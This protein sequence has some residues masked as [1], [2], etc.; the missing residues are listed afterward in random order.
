MKRQKTYRNLLVAAFLINLVGIAF[1]GYKKLDNSIPNDINI[2]VNKS[3]KFDFSLPVEAGIKA[4]DVDAINIDHAKIDKKLIKFNLNSPFVI[5][6]SKEGNYKIDLKLFG[7][8]KW[9][10]INLEVTHDIKLIP[11]GIPIGIYVETDGIMVLGTG[12]IHSMDGL[13][14]EPALNILKSG[15]YITKVNQVKMNT[16]EDLSREIQKS[17]GREISLTIR[18]SDRET[19][20]K[21]KPVKG[22]DGSYKIGAWIRNDTQGIGT[23]TYI[24]SNNDFGALGHGIT[25][26][27]TNLLMEVEGG[28]IYKT[29]IIQI[30]KG[31]KG[32][33]GELVGLIKIGEKNRYGKIL[34]NSNQGIFGTINS[35]LKNYTMRKAMSIGYKQDIKLGRASI[36]CTIDNK[37]QEYKIEIE[38]IELNTKNHSKGLVIRITDPALLNKTNGIVQGMSGSPIIQNNKLIGAVTH[39]FI[40]DSTKGYGTFIEN[41][42]NASE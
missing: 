20:V 26:V 5:Q 36:L 16:K 35:N 27:D 25:D 4:D 3:Q 19:K 23:L 9:K 12:V 38:K 37:V 7:L 11:C 32:I 2:V 34:K 31:K 17:N 24:D 29:D 30:E 28:S 10:Q 8:I 6:S 13:N 39:V 21:I 1:L 33:P 18:R 14:Y 15:D 41:M 40:Q 22:A 42:L